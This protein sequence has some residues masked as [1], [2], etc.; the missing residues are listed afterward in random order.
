LPTSLKKLNCPIQQGLANKNPDVDAI[1]RMLMPLPVHFK[2]HEDIALGGGSWCPFNSQNTTWWKE[3]FPLLYL[4]SYCSFRMTDIYRSLIAQRIAKGNGWPIMFHQATVE[5][6]RNQHN[7]MKDFVDEIPGYL[8]VESIGR[9]LD[10]ISIKAGREH[11]HDAMTLCY[12]RLVEEK[13]F[14]AKEI[15]LLHAWLKDL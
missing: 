12:T 14:D 6:E 15:E 4:P 11:L 7:L 9:Y 8:Q 5:Q 1:Y 10:A 3:A 13:I 2:D